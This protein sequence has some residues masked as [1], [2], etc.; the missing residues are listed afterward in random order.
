MSAR[1]A[2]RTF[3]T[4]IERYKPEIQTLAREARSFVQG[5]LPG[6]EEVM[7][8]AGPF[9]FYGYGP[10]C[11]D[12][13]CTLMISKTGVKIGLVHGSTLAD[14]RRLLRGEGKVHR[15]VPLET[16]SDLRQPGLKALVRAAHA[17]CR[18]RSSQEE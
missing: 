10:G 15:H 16:P 11:R 7:D 13:V 18:K 2:V 12:V 3:D 5:L 9:A 1:A 6:A 8:T 17:A 14:P 4:V